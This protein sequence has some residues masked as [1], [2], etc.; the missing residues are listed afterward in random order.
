M[1]AARESAH[2]ARARV[3]LRLSYGGVYI[4]F[5]GDFIFDADDEGERGFVHLELFEGYD[6]LGLA[7]NRSGR[8]QG[9]YVP[10]YP[11]LSLP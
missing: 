11:R 6:R 10:G 5:E 8:E 7:R 2:R 4:Y 3:D 9:G 1:G